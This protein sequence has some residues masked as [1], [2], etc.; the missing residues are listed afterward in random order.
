MVTNLFSMIG[1]GATERWVAYP[2]VFWL[3]GLGGF[4][5]GFKKNSLVLQ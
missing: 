2:A 5:L 3:I 4:L 1:A